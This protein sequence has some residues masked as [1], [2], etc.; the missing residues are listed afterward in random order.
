[1]YGQSYL[2]SY[3]GEEIIRRL[4]NRLYERIIDLPLLFFREK[5]GVLMSRITYDV[6][7]VKNMVSTAVTGSVRDVFS[8]SG[9]FL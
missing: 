8:I 2:M 1:M 6:N 3:V 7:I 4:R 9:L 5:T